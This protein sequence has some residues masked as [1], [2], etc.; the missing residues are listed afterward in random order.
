VLG[1]R[2]EVD[3]RDVA[4]LLAA[5][6]HGQLVALI[7][8]MR[9]IVVRRIRALQAVLED[10]IGVLVRLGLLR[11]LRGLSAG[12]HHL[13][14]GRVVARGNVVLVA[15]VG[16]DPGRIL[17][18]RAALRPDDLLDLLR[19]LRSRRVAVGLQVRLSHVRELRVVG[20]C[21][22]ADGGKQHHSE[23]RC[24]HD[25]ERFSSEH[26]AQ[27]VLPLIVSAGP[28]PARGRT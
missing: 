3:A 11:F 12:R 4:L 5:D 21:R 9:P 10:E 14:P 15:V 27:G 23:D 20:Q 19:K 2:I 6:R 1:V 18:A 8:E 22:R 7:D 28:A 16:D 25:R 24:A 13:W 26:S 17:E